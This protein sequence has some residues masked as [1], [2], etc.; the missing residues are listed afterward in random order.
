MD[1]LASNM[2]AITEFSGRISDTL[3]DRRHHITKLSGVHML[4]KKVKNVEYGDIKKK[5][6]EHDVI[7]C[8]FGV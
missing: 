3:A 4:L 1:H 6:L 5:E 8:S 2:S 7:C